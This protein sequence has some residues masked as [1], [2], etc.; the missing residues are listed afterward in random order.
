MDNLD[1]INLMKH[2]K[3]SEEEILY[4]LEEMQKQSLETEK[5]QQQKQR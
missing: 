1:I 2:L 4:A 3:Q 5:Q